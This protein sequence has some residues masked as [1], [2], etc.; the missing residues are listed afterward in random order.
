MPASC[1]RLPPHL[2]LTNLTYSL[3]DPFRFIDG[4]TVCDETEW[5]CRAAQLRE[6]FQ[7]YELGYKPPKPPIFS[8]TFSNKTL[9]IVAGISESQTIN[10][11]VPITYP[12]TTGYGPSPAVI[13]YDA[14]SIPVPSQVAVITL[15]VDEIAQ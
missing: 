12:N 13:V 3:P 10:F 14:V 8:S 9:N 15:N 7:N 5:A 6:L 4:A 1:S 2:K 11:S